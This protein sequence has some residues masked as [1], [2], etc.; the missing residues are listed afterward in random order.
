MCDNCDTYMLL[1][2]NHQTFY[3][4]NID[5]EDIL[6]VNTDILN[7]S[8]QKRKDQI[9]EGLRP[10]WQPDEY[11]YQRKMQ[12][13]SPSPS[14]SRRKTWK[15]P[16]IHYQFESFSKFG[17]SSML[18]ILSSP[19]DEGLLLLPGSDGT[20][21]TLSQSDKW[22]RQAKVIDGWTVT[23]TDTAIAFRCKHY[24]QTWPE[25]LIQ[26]NIS[27][28]HLVRI[29][30]LERIPARALPKKGSGHAGPL[31]GFLGLTF[32]FLTF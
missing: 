9:E 24:T 29:L 21:I 11:I 6:G 23:T 30:R 22:L 14:R 16:D 2:H 12:S 19:T 1:C 18:L 17:D 31:T 26:E 4:R 3:I 15:C 7:M 25:L 10:S 20:Q 27:R 32:W 13:R 5:I 8:S 28:I